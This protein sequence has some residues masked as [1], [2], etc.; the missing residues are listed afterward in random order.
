MCPP[1]ARPPS[2]T[3]AFL[4]RRPASARVRRLR[5][6]VLLAPPRG[7]TSG[8]GARTDNS[9]P[10]PLSQP[11]VLRMATVVRTAAWTTM[12]MM[13]TMPTRT[14]SRPRM[15]QSASSSRERTPRGP[16]P[17]HNRPTTGSSNP[18]LEHWNKSLLE[19]YQA[20]QVTLCMRSAPLHA[21][22]SPEF[23]STTSTVLPHNLTILEATN[24]PFRYVH[25][26]CSPIF[27]RRVTS[28]VTSTIL[29]TGVPGVQ[30][31]TIHRRWTGAAW[32]CCRAKSL[33]ELSS[34]SS[35]FVVKQ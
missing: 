30:F 23:A 24:F 17:A 19:R 28:T 1:T 8:R 22:Q 6:Q 34:L 18:A 13:M 31:V 2:L 32:A 25:V 21:L 33:R 12:T 11:P 5:V 10:Y 16:Q 4:S 35:A 7:C 3:P 26:Q 27:H 20:C 15:H 9:I 29:L 14:T